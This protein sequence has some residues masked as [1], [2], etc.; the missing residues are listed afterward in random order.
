MANDKDFILKNAIEVGGSTKVTIGDAPA[1]GSYTVGYDLSVAAYDSKEFDFSN[2]VGAS[3]ASYNQFIKPDG[4]KVY[5]CGYNG[6]KVFQYSLST[7][8]DISTATYD[9]K[10]GNTATQT[11]TGLISASFKSD[12]TK[13]YA[14]DYSGFGRGLYQYTLSTAWDVS[15]ISYDSVVFTDAAVTNTDKGNVFF[16]PD[17]TKFYIQ[18]YASDTITEY[19]CST[20][21]DISTGS[22]SGNS[23]NYS[24]P[25]STSYSFSI[26]NDGKFLFIAALASTVYKYS[27]TTPWDI[28]T[29]TAVSNF[30]TL[31]QIAVNTCAGFMLKDDGT[32][33]YVGRVDNSGYSDRVY[34]YSTSST[35]ATATFDTSTGNYFTHTPSADAEYGFS[36]AGDVQTFQLEV[37]GNQS[38][39]GY[40]LAN[41][42]YSNKMIN[43]STTAQ[44]MEGIFFK[45]DGLTF[46]ALTR[47]NADSVQQYSL[48]TA[49]DI[50][51]CST[52][53]TSSIT[54][55]TQNNSMEGLFF[56]P[57]GTKMYLA[58]NNPNQEVY[59]Y[60]L[61]TAWD[62]STASYNS[63]SVDV[64]ANA[65]P[66]DVIFKPDG[67]KMYLADSNYVE[68]YSLSTAWDITSATHTVRSSAFTTIGGNTSVTAL[69][70][71]ADGSKMFAGSATGGR[72]SEY[73]LTT[74]WDVSTLQ[75]STVDYYVTSA[76][77]SFTDIGAIFF[78]DGA[79]KMY[80]SWR[81]AGRVYQF[82]T[83]A[84]TPITITWDA[85]I[86]WGG[87]T[88][89][90]SPASGQKDLY[91]ITT[92]DGGTTYFGVPS[93][94]AFS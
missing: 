43:L 40:D 42:S 93:G 47:K 70:F 19:N 5:V 35:V 58:G 37:T 20:A 25:I 45:P 91:T 49:W 54:V 88:A 81:G 12:G 57:D 63:V 16:K 62:L 44:D 11:T 60:D 48:T 56:K 74:A 52:T 8:W 28:S 39:V 46:Y 24:P 4:T 53:A 26:S 36:N 80:L 32:K 92:D 82:N 76:D 87:G 23:Y 2:E 18:S 21:W 78:G 71:N 86:E 9:S 29:A 67:T 84:T 61:S 41:A 51:T 38:V 3:L 59:E 22:A 72:I 65:Y 17:G 7:A 31:G 89:P 77:A 10:F 50:S 34:Q 33:M 6:K 83:D 79:G 30:S 64:S 68:E 75:T 73:D 69:A 27:L 14:L 15:T 66:Y 55:Q 94:V 90:S 1:S 85:D 13:M